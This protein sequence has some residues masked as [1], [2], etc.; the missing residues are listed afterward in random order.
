MSVNED[1]IILI[2]NGNGVPVEDFKLESFHFKIFWILR[3][4]LIQQ[5]VEENEA[6]H[7]N[8]KNRSYIDRS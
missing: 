7:R 4:L 2:W 6:R 8:Y 5:L 1:T 3:K